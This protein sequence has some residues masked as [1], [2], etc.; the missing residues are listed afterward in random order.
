MIIIARGTDSMFAHISKMDQIS[1]FK[2][3]PPP[4]K[5]YQQSQQTNKCSKHINIIMIRD[6][7]KILHICPH[8]KYENR[9]FHLW[10]VMY[11]W[12]FGYLNYHKNEERP[13]VCSYLKDPSDFSR[14]NYHQRNEKKN[15]KIQTISSISSKDTLN[16]CWLKDKQYH[17]TDSIFA[18][19]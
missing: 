19:V 1:Y 15:M 17:R 13:N 6:L 8:L 14:L 3:P 4:L 5:K 10:I 7:K 12:T 9:N 18:D 16:I 11:I 2:L